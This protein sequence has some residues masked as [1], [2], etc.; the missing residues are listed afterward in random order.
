MVFSPE[1][2]AKCIYWFITPAQIFVMLLIENPLH[3]LLLDGI[4]DG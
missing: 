4:E 2:Q 3:D 1:D